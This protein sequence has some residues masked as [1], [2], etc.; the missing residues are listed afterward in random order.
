MPQQLD[1]IVWSRSPPSCRCAAENEGWRH[2][3]GPGEGCRN[4]GPPSLGP[5]CAARRRPEQPPGSPAPQS[6]IGGVSRATAPGQAGRD[7][8][9]VAIY[10]PRMGTIQLDEDEADLLTVCVRDYTFD[11]Q[12][13]FL[14]LV[15]P[16]VPAFLPPKVK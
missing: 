4:Q 13:R 3:V 16:V 6:S 9:I 8:V 1:S 12:S 7:A 2:A 15:T 14:S 11:F 10:P 5:R